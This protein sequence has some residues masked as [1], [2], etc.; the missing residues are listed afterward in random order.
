MNLEQ[1]ST[2]LADHGTVD[3]CGYN[4]NDDTKLI[5]SIKNFDGSM[6]GIVNFNSLAETDILPEFPNTEHF[7]VHKGAMK[8]VFKK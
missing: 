7:N 5:L 4:G 8:A 1:L 3:F 2:K 6:A